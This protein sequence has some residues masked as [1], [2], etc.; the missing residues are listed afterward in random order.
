LKWHYQCTPGDEWD[1]DAIQHLML[2]DIRINNRNRKV[3]MQA[4]KNGYFY[5]IDRT[6]R[7]IHL[8]V[9][10]VAGELGYGNRSENRPSQHSSR[11]ALF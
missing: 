8:G 3:I 10:D 7:R 9:R 4:N 2:A 11:R 1:Y 5:V 6:E